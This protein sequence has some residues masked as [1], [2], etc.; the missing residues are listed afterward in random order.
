MDRCAKLIRRLRE[1]A[2]L[3]QGHA[4]GVMGIGLSG[5]QFR[6]FPQLGH[7]L[8]EF[9]FQFERQP[10]VVMQRRVP[11]SGLERGLKPGNRGIK[12]SFLQVSDS[13]VSFVSAVIGT[14]TKRGLKLGDGNVGLA[15]LDQG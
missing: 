11:G 8:G 9:I 10:Q 7:G 12:V 5:I 15:E 2:L 4:Q 14:Q 3:P 6:S 1:L 13:Q